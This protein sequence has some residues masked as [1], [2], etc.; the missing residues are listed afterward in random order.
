MDGMNLMV[1]IA[2]PEADAGGSV[3]QAL[4]CIIAKTIHMPCF[5]D[6]SVMSYAWSPPER[7]APA[8]VREFP[9]HAVAD[10]GNT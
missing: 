5:V 8:I 3:A 9:L 6:E 1:E 2:L 10:R 4:H 7:P